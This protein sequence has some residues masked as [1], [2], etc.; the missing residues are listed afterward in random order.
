MSNPTHK[1][2]FFERLTGSIRMEEDEPVVMTPP[3]R[4]SFYATRYEESY[5]DDDTVSANIEIVQQSDPEIEEEPLDAQLAIDMHETNNDIII[6]TMTAGVKKEDLHISISRDLVTIRGKRENDPRA[7]QHH[8][9]DQ[10]LYWGPFSREIPLPD[11]VAID[12]A[13]ATEYHGLVTI[14]LPKFDKKRKA[15]LRIQ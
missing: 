14:K 13:T 10:E 5:E 4:N 15:T 2:S 3:K 7:Y 6:K 11:E 9:H 12:D 8:Y 1:R